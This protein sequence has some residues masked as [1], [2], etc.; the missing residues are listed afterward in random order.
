MLLGRG[1]EQVRIDALL[2]QARGGTSGA[3]V[4][5]GEPGIGKSALLRYAVDQCHDMTVLSA[6]GIETESELAFAGLSELLHPVLG[7][8]DEIPPPQVS[9]LAGALAVGPPGALDRFTISV[10]TLSLLAAAAE[11][12]PV[13]AV[14]DDAHWL[15]APSREALLFAARRLLA[16]RTVLLFAAR[17]GEPMTF[18]APAVPELMLG[19]IDQDA[20]NALLVSSGAPQVSAVVARTIL[21]ATRGNPLAILEVPRVLSPGQ[22]SG[23][24]PLDEPLPVGPGVQRSFARR[25]AHLPRQT[26]AALLVAAASQS[27]S[28]DEVRRACDALGIDYA[29]LEHAERDG[30]IENDGLLIQFGHPLIRAAVY[31][32]AAAPERR[33]AHRALAS[34]LAGEPFASQRAWHLAAAVDG[35]DEQ[36]AAAL[37]HA[38]REARERSGHA[39]AASAFERAARLTPDPEHRARRLLEAGVDAHVAGEWARALALLAEALQHASGAT[40]RADIEHARGRVEMWTRSPKAARG[41][42]LAAAD[43]IEAYDAARAALILVDAATTCYMEDDPD[44]GVLRSALEISGRAHRLGSQVGGLT[45]AAACGLLGKTLTL[46]GRAGEGYPLLVRCHYAIEESDSLWLTFQL[47][48]CVIVFL[49]LEEYSLARRPLEQLIA[50]A[51]ST[52]APVALLFPLCNLSE[53]DYRMGRWREAYAEAAEATQLAEELGQ[54]TTLVYALVCLGWVEAAMGME[55]DCRRH[56]A[57]ALDIAGPT[58]TTIVAYAFTVLGLLELGLGHNHEAIQHLKLVSDMYNR[59]GTVE[60]AVGQSAPNLIEAYTRVGHREEAKTALAVFGDHAIKTKGTWAR[61]AAA[62][63]RGILA[64]KDFEMHFEEALRLH[65]RTPTP[66]ERARTELCYGERL[67]RARRRAEARERLRSALDAFE[68]LGAAPWAERARTELRATGMAARKRDRT[69]SE[70]LTT[71]ELQVALKVATGATNREV[72]MALFLSPKT[73]EAHLG[74]VYSKLGLRSRT[75]LAHYFGREGGMSSPAAG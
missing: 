48:Q 22:L 54:A 1:A 23:S 3:L 16:D 6:T 66:F 35:A 7:L 42:L 64:D 33:A 65:E 55:Q 38:A 4:I 5:R 30:L 74:H 56:V 41:I 14:I 58:R 50:E 12:R 60:E 20:C 51:R 67:R 19:G 27:R 69:E 15:D 32:G 57:A 34:A 10:A 71:Q 49:W 45:E 47:I 9:A 63:C 24:E 8:L 37:E 13:L 61:A 31:H 2:A 62:R 75:E 36:V 52:S 11:Q 21:E 25:V 59:E 40:L 53:V 68:R 73:I 46:L 43:S 70:Q 44:Q 39:S 17:V 28:S 72:A 29:A 26:R 18:E